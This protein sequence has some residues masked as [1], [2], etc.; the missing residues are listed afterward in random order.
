MSLATQS[1][2]RAGAAHSALSRAL[3]VLTPL[4]DIVHQP[5]SAPEPP[6]WCRERGWDEFLLALD[7]R[8][9]ESFEERGLY[10]M[11]EL[12]M[13]ESLARLTVAVEH[14]TH[15]PQLHPTELRL[16]SGSLR[17]VAARK[18]Q[19][20]ESL[21]GAVAGMAAEASR[22]V[23]VGAGSGHLARLAAEL[24]QRQTLALD[25]DAAR[26]AHG[27]LR[28]AERA[29]DVEGLSVQFQLVDACESAPHLTVDDLAIGLHACGELGDG[30]V[31]AAAGA[32]CDLALISCCL[33]KI[34]A[35]ARAPLSLAAAHLP[36]AREALGLC[37]L[38]TRANGVEA[39]LKD[40]LRARETRFALRQLL[41]A[42]GIPL[43]AG[44]EMRGV[45]RRR[46]HA[47][48]AE[49][50][51]RVLEVRSLPAPSAAELHFHE[52][53]AARDYARVRR[54]SLPRNLLARLVE[55]AVI[56]DRGAAL[57]AAGHRVCIATIFERNVSP[58][59]VGIF[60]SRVP[61]R[62]P[63]LAATPR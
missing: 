13:P 25:R 17:G 26:I 29:R 39:S 14:A 38:S 10:T 19:Q 7:D 36:L 59:N 18:R 46:A 4:L 42:R 54:L 9:L 51:T 45:N 41:L 24:F 44:A 21:L 15:V 48:L 40:N 47:G 1:A 55:L 34:R 2:A 28:L 23:D 16:P 53:S 35:P 12:E 11:R 50:A 20:L 32:G 37:N 62:L 31:M 52:Q 22:I 33:Q 6:A 30:L 27:S 58:R 60:A 8:Q 5:V 61:E 43:A 57:E 56:F 49:L 3:G 63:R